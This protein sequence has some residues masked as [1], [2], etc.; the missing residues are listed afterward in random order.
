MDFDFLRPYIPG[1]WVTALAA[2]P[3]AERG[4]LQ[5]LRL[6][7]RQPVTVSTPVGERFLCA[8][9]LT[10]LYQQDVFSCS[11]TVLEDCFLA[12]CQQ[13]VYA[14]QEELRQGFLSAP[15]GV[16][17][18]IA[19]RVVCDG[20][21]VRAVTD[22]TGLCVRLPR[23]HRGCAVA[24]LPTV[25][26]AGRLHSTLLVGEP[27]CGKTSLLRDLAAQLTA[28]RVRVAVVDER[29]E[30]AGVDS[31][32]GCDVLTGCPK[33]AGLRQ[34]VRCLAPQAVLFDELGQQEEVAAVAACAH[35]GVSVVASLHGDSP[36][37]MGRQ[38]LVRELVA[39][40]VFERWVF[41]AGRHRPGE[42]HRCLIPEVRGYEVA[43]RDADSGGRPGVGPV[44]FPPLVSAG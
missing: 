4:S 18:G 41:L 13:A 2:L 22:V 14:H 32:P 20:G 9:G 3:S 24:L 44:L 23:R 8:A 15:G 25:L 42:I 33:A 17:V 30:L 19:G 34:A 31:L 11:P 5:E 35:A 12:F 38:P 6:R 26:D 27:A 1:E 37:A 39:Q 43:W 29:G 16:R 21:R 40:N 10:E 36:A 7:R 28:R